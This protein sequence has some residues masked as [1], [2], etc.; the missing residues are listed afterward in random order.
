MSNYYDDIRKE[1][2]TN[3]QDAMVAET[4]LENEKKILVDRFKNGVGDDLRNNGQYYMRPIS[5]KKPFK[6]RFKSFVSK[7]KYIL[8][9]GD[10]DGA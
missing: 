8:F 5:Y 1:I 9:G 10:Y 7:I 6:I 2:M 4:E 3:K